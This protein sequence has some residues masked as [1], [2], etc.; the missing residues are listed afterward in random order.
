MF[1]YPFFYYP[2]ERADPL[3]SIR[4]P[5]FV[6][7]PSAYIPL[8]MTEEFHYLDTTTETGEMAYLLA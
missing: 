7:K 8:A 1:T 5:A 6:R 3:Q 2:N 4:M